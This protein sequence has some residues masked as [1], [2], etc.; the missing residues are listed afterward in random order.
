MNFYSFMSFCYDMLDKM[1]FSDKG[2][3]PRENIEQLIPDKQSTVLD[4]CCGTF[5]NGL[6]IA[7]KNPKN[8]LVGLD[9]SEAMLKV[10]KKKTEKAGLKN[11]SFLCRDATDTELE[12]CS[13][14]YICDSRM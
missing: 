3:N 5:S 11:V 6:P 7:K 1:W 10:A 4:M 14:D 8:T 9:R 2:Q 13:F 12:S